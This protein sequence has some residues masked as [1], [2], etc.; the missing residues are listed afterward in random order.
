MELEGKE[1]LLRRMEVSNV[2]AVP[3]MIERNNAV[4]LYNLLARVI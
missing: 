1:G 4:D 2:S 3:A